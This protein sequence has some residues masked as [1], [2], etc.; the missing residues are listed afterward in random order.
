MPW[1]SLG[2]GYDDVQDTAPSSPSIGD[3]WLDTSGG[4]VTG[5][6]YADLGNGADWQI[7][8]VQDELQS[9]RTRELLLLLQNKPVLE[10]QDPM[11]VQSGLSTAYT[12]DTQGDYIIG[13]KKGTTATRTADDDSTSVSEK[14]GLIINPNVSLL[15]ITAEVS[16]NT[17]NLGKAYLIRNSDDTVLDSTTDFDSGEVRL[18]ANLS[19]GTDYQIVA[20]NQGNGYTVGANYSLSFPFTSADIDITAGFDGFDSNSDRGYNFVSVSALNP[21]NSAEVTD[22]FAVQ[23]TPLI[24]IKQWHTIQARDVKS[25]GSTSTVPVEFD[26]LNSNIVLNS[27]RIPKERITD[28][29]FKLRNRVYSESAGSDGQSDYQIATT[30]DGGHFGIPVLTVVSVK[31]NGSVLDSGGWSFDGDTTVTIDTSNVTIA[32]GDTIEIKYDFD[33]FDSTLQ[34]RAYLSRE[35][36][37]ETSPSISH[38]KYEYVI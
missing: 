28:E 25:G 2:G 33:V 3:T 34:P 13:V 32:S 1:N 22:Q 38:F 27:T 29:P 10:V 37:D 14:R 31:K 20:D 11:N 15:G 16:S 7:L 5:K 9:G 17:S 24:G 35:S 36:T 30:G 6:I 21:T 4:D 26:I 8:P 23:T 19:S 18:E 12:T